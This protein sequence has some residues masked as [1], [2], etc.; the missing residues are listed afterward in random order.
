MY[1]HQPGEMTGDEPART[2]IGEKSVTIAGTSE[3]VEFP[4]TPELTGRF[5]FTAEVEPVEGEVVTQNNR[6]EREVKIIDDFLRLMFV[7]CGSVE[8]KETLPLAERLSSRQ[9]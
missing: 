5:I 3:Q 7:A 8:T 1:A 2:L 6:A 4:Y 9:T